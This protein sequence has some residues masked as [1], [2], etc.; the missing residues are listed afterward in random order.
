MPAAN[1]QFAISAG[2]GSQKQLFKFESELPVQ[3]AV[4][5][6]LRQAADRY[7]QANKTKIYKKEEI[8]KIL[9]RVAININK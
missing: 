9:K 3:T 1:K 6:H 7:Q 4:S 5:R 8:A 2:V